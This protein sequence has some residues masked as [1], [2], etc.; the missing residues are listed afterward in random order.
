MRAISRFK[1]SPKSKNLIARSQPELIRPISSS[2][3]TLTSE[4]FQYFESLQTMWNEDTHARFTASVVRHSFISSLADS[5][6]KMPRHSS[7]RE[8]FADISMSSK[9]NKKK[10]PYT[11]RFLRVCDNYFLSQFSINLSGICSIISAYPTIR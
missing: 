11:K 2:E 10:N 6:T 9:K 4:G 3:Q 8:R 5:N 1:E 7:S